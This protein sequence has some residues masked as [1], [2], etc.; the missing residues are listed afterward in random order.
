VRILNQQLQGYPQTLF[1]SLGFHMGKQST[2]TVQTLTS[3]RDCKEKKNQQL[4]PEKLKVPKH[5]R[6]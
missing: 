2:H 1:E 5:Q 6:K 4:T 3:G